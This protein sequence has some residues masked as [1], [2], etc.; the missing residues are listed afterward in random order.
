MLTTPYRTTDGPN[1]RA[2]RH[3]SSGT[4]EPHPRRS[5]ALHSRLDG[6]PTSPGTATTALTVSQRRWR[7]VWRGFRGRHGSRLISTR[8]RVS[9]ALLAA[10]RRTSH[11]CGDP[12]AIPAATA[13]ADSMF[14]HTRIRP[15]PAT[16]TATNS[17]PGLLRHCH[18]A[19]HRQGAHPL[20]RVDW[21]VLGK[22]RAWGDVLN[23]TVRAISRHY[24]ESTDVDASRQGGLG[25]MQALAFQ[26]T[27]LSREHAF[28]GLLGPHGGTFD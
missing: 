3:A 15:G 13:D 9:T 20:P 4:T 14:D 27:L 12:P 7:W 16:S 11:A 17:W 5:L 18:R 26:N 2:M 6:P 28:K 19:R 24:Y 10:P 21:R 1:L 22:T 23:E 8:K 25:E